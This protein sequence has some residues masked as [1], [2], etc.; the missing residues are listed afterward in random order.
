MGNFGVEAALLT[1]AAERENTFI[2]AASDNLT[3]QA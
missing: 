1:D 3:A 2:L